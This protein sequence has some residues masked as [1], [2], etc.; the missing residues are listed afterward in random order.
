M[1]CVSVSPVM[2]MTGTWAS[3]LLRLRRRVV[4]KPS[5]L[6]MTASIRMTSG[7]IL[8]TIARACAPSSATSTVIPASSSASVSMR[9]VS[10]E[11][12]TTSTISPASLGRIRPPLRVED[13]QQPAQIER[14][15][16]GTQFRHRG[17]AFRGGRLDLVERCADT[18][19][20]ADLAEP[21]QRVDGVRGEALH[22][23]FGGGAAPSLP[24]LL[25]RVVMR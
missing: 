5:M 11:S 17:G 4:S 19:E 16:D 12:S 6:G 24:H 3:V 14:I 8:P 25:F 23:A 18:A 21:D 20:V 1:S 13:S 15:G 10:G 2:K 9:R 7:V 22:E